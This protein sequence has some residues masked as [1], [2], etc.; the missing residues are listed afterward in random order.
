MSFLAKKRE[1]SAL[2][3][4]GRERTCAGQICCHNFAG[5][6]RFF[7][8]SIRQPGVL[9]RDTLLY[10]LRQNILHL[11]NLRVT[12]ECKVNSGR[13]FVR[14]A[15]VCL[16]RGGRQRTSCRGKPIIWFSMSRLVCQ[17]H[18]SSLLLLYKN[19]TCVGIVGRLGIHMG[20]QQLPWVD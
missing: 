10:G 5:F 11:F 18:R 17:T 14:G 13:W 12:N 8:H 16:G 6:H 20:T 3:A 19:D 15:V 1:K 4:G 9:Q 2:H 7:T